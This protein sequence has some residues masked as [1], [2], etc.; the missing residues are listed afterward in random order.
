MSGFNAARDWRTDLDTYIGLGFTA[1][2]IP[3]TIAD[4]GPPHVRHDLRDYLRYARSKGIARVL[5]LLDRDAF[6]WPDERVRT[7]DYVR[8][9]LQLYDGLYDEIQVGNESDLRSPASWD[10]PPDRFSALLRAVRDAAPGAYLVA[11][12]M[13]SG[14][15]SYLDGVDLGPVDAI[16]CLVPDQRVTARG[17][18]HGSMRRYQGDVVTIET[19]GGHQ[20]TCTPN[21]PILT[22]QGWL[23]AC[24]VNKGSEVVQDTSGDAAPTGANDVYVPTQISEVF[25][26]LN[27][28]GHL[29]TRP[30][31][32]LDFH[33]DG[34]H[35]D[36]YVVTADRLLRNPFAQRMQHVG[37]VTS[38]MRP[39][40]L[41]AEGI[42][43]AGRFGHRLTQRAR[44]RLH[45]VLTQ[46]GALLR[47][48]EP[49][50]LGLAAVSYRKAALSE[51]HVDTALPY[52]KTRRNRPAGFARH[53]AFVERPNILVRQASGSA[54][55][56]KVEAP[57][58]ELLGKLGAA[59]PN[60]PSKYLERLSG[61]VAFVEIIDVR[62]KQ[63]DGHVYNL[64]TADGL[65]CADTVVTH[66]CHPYLKDAP[67]QDDLE[68][69]PDV[70]EL[71]RAYR[72][73]GKPVVI[74]E[75]GFPRGDRQAAETR[76]MLLWA[77]AASASGEIDEFYLFDQIPEFALTDEAL[78][79]VK[80]T[81]AYLAA[82]KP[83]PVDPAP[84]PAPVDPVPE[85][86]PTPEVRIMTLEDVQ[87]MAYK[88]A[89]I[90]EPKVGDVNRDGAI[91]RAWKGRR[92]DVGVP[93]TGEI[94]LDD[95]RAA[96][97]CSSGKLLVWE[98]GDKVTTV[99]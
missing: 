78:A 16:A 99:G 82:V 21:H 73:Y 75:W 72:A 27:L 64:S 50:P 52:P 88:V 59:Y 54:A 42:L 53:V 56:A 43:A 9:W 80:E 24:R 41:P 83:A 93:M 85:S 92:A 60:A 51:Q 19:A 89:E 44:A 63:F 17:P 96:V 1:M 94:A 6:Y 67:N 77:D 37:F 61:D 46:S 33:G 91:Y 55:R 23:P 14:D 47:S 58:F 84:T 26:A 4:A 3:V 39:V 36:V 18:T 62:V 86:T 15:P 74:S 98:G 68:D 48:T 79:A 69:Q 45:P 66:N 28:S 32:R 35:G 25:R 2:R 11:G 49:L 7:A 38:D 29:R 90:R 87:E 71:V 12:G 34:R 40:L 20:V 95:G 8:F 31:M 13:A 57:S 30:G 5:L 70:D 97:V 81:T 76:E 65:I 22:R 10:L